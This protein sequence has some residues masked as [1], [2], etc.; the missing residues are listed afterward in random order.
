MKLSTR[1]RY[2]VKILL[3]IALAGSARKSGENIPVTVKNIAE[4][5]KISEKYMSKLIISLKGAGLIKSFRGTN[6]GYLLSRHPSEINMLEVVKALEGD[7]L[8]PEMPEPDIYC[9]VENMWQGL[10]SVL[11]EYLKNI[12]LNDLAEDY[13]KHNTQAIAFEI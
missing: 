3:E 12:T 9:P 2:G 1:S 8:I 10:R 5:Q 4:K 13:I 7:L 11:E 6:G